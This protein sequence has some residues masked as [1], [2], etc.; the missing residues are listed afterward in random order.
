M[1]ANAE[2]EE[3][4]TNSAKTTLIDGPSVISK[5]FIFGS[6]RLGW[7]LIHVIQT[8]L[9]LSVS[10]VFFIRACNKESCRDDDQKPLHL[11]PLV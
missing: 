4:S 7:R 8:L 1:A 5:A 9:T 10:L 2:D 3:N 6:I 11:E